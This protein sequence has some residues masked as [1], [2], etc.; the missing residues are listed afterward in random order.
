M[1][2][3]SAQERV[4]EAQED[5]TSVESP[6]PTATSTTGGP[7]PSADDAQP[8]TAPGGMHDVGRQSVDDDGLIGEGCRASF[9]S[10]KPPSGP[11]EVDCFG[12]MGPKVGKSQQNDAEEAEASKEEVTEKKEER[13]GNPNQCDCPVTV[14]PSGHG[15]KV[16]DMVLGGSGCLSASRKRPAS[17]FLPINAE[18]K[19]IG[20]EVPRTEANQL[21]SDARRISPVHVSLRERTLGEISVSPDSYFF[22]DSD[23]C[24]SRSNRIFESSFAS[25][26][27]KTSPAFNSPVQAN[28][29][30]Q[31]SEKVWFAAAPEG[32]RANGAEKADGCR[33]L[34][35]PEDAFID[36]DSCCS[37]ARDS[38]ERDLEPCQEKQCEEPIDP[39]AY[40]N[41]AISSDACAPLKEPEEAGS[42]TKSSISCPQMVV[43]LQRIKV[44]NLATP[45]TKEKPAEDDVVCEG[46]A[47]DVD[48]RTAAE[49][50]P[51]ESSPVQRCPYKK[52]SAQKTEP[53]DQ[54]TKHVS[55]PVASRSK[56][57]HEKS[58]QQ[59]IHS[60]LECK[61]VLERVT[62]SKVVRTP[63]KESN[64][65][66]IT[67]YI[68]LEKMDVAV[69]SP[70]APTAK[71]AQPSNR[72]DSSEATP[73]SPEEALE[74]STDVPEAVDTETE[75]E[76]GSDSSE[77]SSVANVRLRGCDEDAVSDQISCPESESMCCVD[78]N[79][80][81]ITRLEAERPEPFTEDSA[82]SLAL[83]TG[84]RDEV[85]SDG[86][87]SGLGSE[88]PGDPGPAPAPESDS[89]T[90]F[91]DRIP[92]D[93]LS[94][95]EKGNY[96][97]STRL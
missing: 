24:M 35:Y 12:A 1:E 33:K 74:P 19:R 75:T 7:E 8:P 80:E 89:E 70:T 9:A 40:E 97:S 11:S 87:D 83:A 4:V 22:D 14:S 29:T 52:Q 41:V 3:P 50:S 92:D 93:I 23:R 26:R 49:D 5:S 88:I 15:D 71:T 18:I 96:R 16:E 17:D 27:L 36:G 78:I 72:V 13:T 81:I 66:E 61:V 31:S 57:V 85:R 51:K 20:V 34:E 25:A 45:E 76:T 64:K 69:L 39:C 58:E 56:T 62:S 90:S 42:S 82:E 32:E 48:V 65:N 44:S 6:G 79:P 21:R 60:P 43:M 73:S 54:P 55:S 30:M 47:G 67:P 46:G 84:A 94:D 2:S 28:E 63:T 86:S 68:R 10:P 37:L 95:K 77:V 59:G 38:P 53:E 91:L